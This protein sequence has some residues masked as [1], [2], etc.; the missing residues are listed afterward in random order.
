MIT[1]DVAIKFIVMLGIV[2]LFADVTYEGARSIVGP[3][4]STFGANAAIVGSVVGLG[5]L[6]GYGMRGISGYLSD[7]TRRY[8][9]ITFIGYIVNLLAVPLLA[10]AGSWKMAAFLIILERCGKA[11]RV[12]AR[13]AMLS[14]ATKHTGRGW[15]FGL[16]EGL[17][18]IGAVL[19][20]VI[21]AGVL[22]FR[23]SYQLAFAFLLIP[24]LLSLA[25]LMVARICYPHPERMEV[26]HHPLEA[27]GFSRK[28]WIYLLAVGLVAAGFV[29]F[30][31]I[32]Y[33]FE[34]ASAVSVVWIP[35]LYSIAMGV[36]GLAALIIGRLFDR[37]GVSVLALVTAIS[38]LFA[39]LVFMENFYCILIGIILWGIGLGSQESIMRAIVADLVPPN[40]RGSAY[41]LLNL[42]FGVFWA[43]GSALKGVFYDFSYVYLVIFSLIAQL[44]SIPFFLAARARS[45]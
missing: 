17:D 18:Q 36:D 10:L 42:T 19:G 30:A 8:W 38:A 12:P 15:G 32:A 16:H 22:Y 28:Y 4:L 2:S 31:L 23:G 7:K 39:P 41:G 6:I 33:H 43:V 21:V 1:R 29:D 14:Y 44:A 11:I 35:L 26:E 45:K 20:P 34:R 40:K 27:K 25:M 9:A 5:E 3:Y 13:D 24:A 37:K